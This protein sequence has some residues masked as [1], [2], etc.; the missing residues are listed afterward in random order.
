[1]YA[2]GEYELSY[3][4]KTI[5]MSCYNKSKIVRFYKKG[6]FYEL[7]FLSYVAALKLNG[8]YIDVGQNVGNHSIFFASCTEADKVVGFE[9]MREL[10]D[11][12]KKI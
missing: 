9:A 10:F 5:A 11:M 2:S 3:N 12:C 6:V 1:M 7:D 8:D 4:G